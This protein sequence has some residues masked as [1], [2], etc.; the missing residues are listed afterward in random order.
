MSQ[1]FQSRPPRRAPRITLREP[2]VVTIQ[3]ENRRQIFAQLH[4]VSIT[5]GLL[6]LSTCLEERIW[7]G[8]TLRIGSSVVRP[9]AEM[10]FPLRAAAG[11]LQ[12]YRITRIRDEERQM[13]DREIT[14]MRKRAL[15]PLTP[16]H[17]PGFRPPHYYLEST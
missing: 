7:V 5:G 14:E 13:L 2:V 17:G 6:E 3:L 1:F 8:L 15:A 11:Y 16:G 9:T 4:Q 10:M 12:P